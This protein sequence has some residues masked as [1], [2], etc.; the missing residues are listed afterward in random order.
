MKYTVW[1]F[2]VIALLSSIDLAMGYKTVEF[3]SE[4]GGK[5]EAPGKLSD[6]TRFAFD[7]NGSIYVVDTDV[8]RLQKLRADGSPILEITAGDG[9]LF[10]RPMDVAVD[11]NL[12]IYVVDWKSV[13]IKGTDS[14]K[15]FNYGPCVHKFSSDG[16]FIN[17]FTLEDLS[18]KAQEQERAV[19][20]VDTDGSFALMIVPQKSDRQL[21]ISADAEGNV[22]VL[23]QDTIYKLNP[24]GEVISRFA[25]PGRLDEATGIAVDTKGNTYVADTGNHR[26]WKFGPD[27]K[28]LLSF[29]EKGDSDGQ[30]MDSLYVAAAWNGSILVADSASYEKIL[31][32]S[33]KQR[34]IINSS[35]LVTGQDDP[36]IPKT[37]DFKTVIRRFQRFDGDGSFQE[38]ILYR[39][40]KSD[41]EMRGFKFKAIDPDG[42]LYLIDKDTLVVRKYSAR[43]PVRWSEIDKTF[44][45][46]MQYSDGR[47]QIDNFY[48][49]NYAY[50]FSERE[51]YTQMIATM[52]FNYDMTEVFGVS[53]VTS[54][55]RL[56]GTTYDDY[57]GEYA[58]P[59][60]YVQ[61]DETTDKYT[62]IRMRLDFSLVLD[63]DP[64]RYRVGDLFLYFGGGRYDFDIVATDFQNRRRLDED[65][66]WAVWAV[67]MKYDMGHSLRLSLTAAQHRP[68]GF[69][70]YYYKYWDEQG[71]LYGTG[72]GE[73]SSTEVFLSVDGAF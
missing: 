38:K 46:Q 45:Y 6:E 42:N 43:A 41:P 57:P 35:I 25:D 26:I 2:A 29:G 58:D 53:F 30:F 11:G 70:N 51:T 39:I 55:T 50:D 61:D 56:S 44:S 4:F 17:T 22:Y 69:M 33:V 63:H 64:F 32:T 34:K 21:Y 40:D 12:N 8:P 19:P 1:L 47:S 66:W 72:S 59:S 37:R 13:H 49:L 7:K 9:F 24:S 16:T 3:S 14:P 10:M 31:K 28:F 48:D 68:P 36:L 65:L 15:I 71:E 73:G 62:A 27:G 20:A 5:G 54:L 23:D 60:G 18:Q 52:R 67:G